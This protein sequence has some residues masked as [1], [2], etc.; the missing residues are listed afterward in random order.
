MEVVLIETDGCQDDDII[1]Q[2]VTE[3]D[4]CGDGDTQEGEDEVDGV[5]CEALTERTNSVMMAR[6][7]MQAKS[8][9][10][11]MNVGEYF[12]TSIDEYM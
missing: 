5:D 8:L 11:S 12:K 6:E 10:T 9:G 4:G 1:L 3:T 2:S 7:I